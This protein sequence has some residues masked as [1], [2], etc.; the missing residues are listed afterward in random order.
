MGKRS[1]SKKKKGGLKYKKL[2]PSRVLWYIPI[3]PR[4]QKAQAGRLQVQSQP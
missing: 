1:D 2:A 4:T 3:I